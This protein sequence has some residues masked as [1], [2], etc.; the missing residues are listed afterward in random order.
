MRAS[1]GFQVSLAMLGIALYIFSAAYVVAHAV[2]FF[3]ARSVYRHMDEIRRKRPDPW[4]EETTNRA[5]LDFRSAKEAL[6]PA[7]SIAFAA[8]VCGACCTI[9]ARKIQASQGDELPPLT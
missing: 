2:P 8:L 1:Y 4:M 9:A 5:E 3:K 7:V 6:I